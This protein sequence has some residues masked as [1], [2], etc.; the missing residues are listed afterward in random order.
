MFTSKQE[1]KE[2]FH[3]IKKANPNFATQRIINRF[4][5]DS[6]LVEVYNTLD[7]IYG[8][9]YN[10]NHALELVKCLQYDYA[11]LYK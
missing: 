10:K 6:L 9:Y 3:T 4:K 11:Y 8:N 7:D 5:S 2:V 1:L